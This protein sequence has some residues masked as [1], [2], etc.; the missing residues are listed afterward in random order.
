MRYAVIEDGVVINAIL[1]D[2]PAAWPLPAGT[3]LVASDLAGPGWSYAD[4]EFTAP[5]EPEPPQ[6]TEAPLS[7]QQIAC[8][9]LTVDGWDVTGLE[10]STGIAGAF[11]ADTDTAWLLFNEPQ[12]DT[13]YIV[14]PSDGVTKFPEFIQVSREGL[15]DISLLVFRVQ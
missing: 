5:S 14:M 15:A 9:R 2:D 7:L 3:Q 4:G 13:E 10:R 11:V 8:A 6:E 1:L 12:T